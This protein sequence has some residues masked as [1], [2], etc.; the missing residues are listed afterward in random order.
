M[1]PANE[2]PTEELVSILKRFGATSASM[3]ESLDAFIARSTG[4]N[5]APMAGFMLK[6]AA[7]ILS[8]FQEVR[9]TCMGNYIIMS[10]A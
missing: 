9:F 10:C 8:T 6:V 3:P 4:G 2:A 5:V 1:F 7:I